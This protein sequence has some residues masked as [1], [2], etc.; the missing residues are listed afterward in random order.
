MVKKTKR[1]TKCKKVKSVS[2]FY[3]HKQHKDGSDSCCKKCRIIAASK[4]EKKNSDKHKNWCRIS[5]LKIN[6][7]LTIKD[8][9]QMFEQQHGCCAI[10]EK[11][12]SELKKPLC[13]DH[14]H[15]TKQ[16]RGLLCYRCN[17]AI[18]ALGADYGTDLLQKAIEYV[19]E[20]NG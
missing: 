20:Y 2:D 5:H 17:P 19:R 13:V 3:K 7:G 4:Y 14:N 10:C 11:H 6:Y 1:C 16:I 8:W 15:E 12:Q 9:E 18:G